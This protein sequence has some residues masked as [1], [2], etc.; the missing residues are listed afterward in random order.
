MSSA[1]IELKFLVP[2]SARAALLEELSRHTATLE[3]STLT[4][5]YLDTADGRLAEIGISWRLRREGRRLVQTLRETGSG[6]ERFEHEV[7]LAGTDPD[8]LAHVG[9]RAGDRLAALIG[10]AQ[11]DGQDTIVRFETQLRRV[12]RRVRSGRNLI[13]VAHDEGRLRTGD[14]QRKL[15]Q[16]EFRLLGGS[17]EGAIALARRWQRRHDL[18]L[19]P[20][21]IAERGDRLADGV[22]HLPI[23]KAALPRYDRHA[24][25]LA[26]FVAVFDE[27][28]AQIGRNAVGLVDGDPAARVEHVHQLRV[29]IRRLRS[30]LSSFR[31]WIPA[32]PAALIDALRRLFARLGEARDADVLD[33]GVVHE[34]RTAG[35]PELAAAPVAEAPDPALVIGETT[36]QQLLLDWL[37]WRIELVAPTPEAP[38][39]AAATL[40]P[41][42][43]P[44]DA[45]PAEDPAPAGA[46]GGAETAVAAGDRAA[47]AEV[48]PARDESE[49]PAVDDTPFADAAARRLRRWHRRIAV[50]IHDFETLD[51]EALHELR[52]RIKRQRYASEFFGP[53]LRGGPL[54]HYLK[55]LAKVQERMGGIN[56]LVVARARYES[57]LPEEPAAWFALGWLSARIVAARHEA[58]P[59]LK[60]LASCATPQGR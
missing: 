36:T 37:A 56:D 60:A 20:R 23:R 55:I 28:F 52:K 6:G 40:V 4:A 45:A 50:A 46:D 26:A 30:A 57:L 35:A 32:P 58:L 1:P 9:T 29:G 25:A 54:K 17:M 16:I 39:T 44:A 42:A 41:S 12:S 11:R 18:V 34:L 19:D 21:G 5:V 3:R 7:L 59:E 49:T 47:E 43:E 53:V 24:A 8:P 48:D 27:C 2:A 33:S 13:E 38:G 15:S 22:L 31:P 51:D 14:R 10:S